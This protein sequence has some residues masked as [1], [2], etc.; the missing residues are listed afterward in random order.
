MTTLLHKK[1]NYVSYFAI[2]TNF[3]A[4]YGYLIVRC[5]KSHCS[6]HVFLRVSSCL[7]NEEMIASLPINGGG[8]GGPVSR[9]GRGLALHRSNSSLELPHS[10][11]P[12]SRVPETPL[13]R[14]Y[15]SHGKRLEFRV[16][17]FTI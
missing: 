16:Y 8:S 2:K 7:Q 4:F 3:Q 9:V 11:D 14:E 1:K 13:R 15:G 12:A 5:R 10:P 6:S 17:F